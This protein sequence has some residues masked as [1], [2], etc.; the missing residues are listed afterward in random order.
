MFRERNNPS[1]SVSCPHQRVNV[2]VMESISMLMVVATKA[3]GKV[4]PER[5]N[6]FCHCLKNQQARLT[7]SDCHVRREIQWSGNMR[8]DRWSKVSRRVESWSM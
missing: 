6:S 8:M 3:D 5:S 1:K 2:M 7:G 4:S